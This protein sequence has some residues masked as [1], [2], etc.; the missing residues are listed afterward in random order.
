MED[1]FKQCS[2]CLH[3]WTTRDGFLADPDVHLVGYQANF[4][5]LEAGLFLFNHDFPD[6]G[7]TLAIDAARF[8]DLYHGPVFSERL[9]LT[10][11]CPRYCMQQEELRPCPA[12]CECAYVREVSDIVRNW[13]K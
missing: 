3:S 13:P 6:C 1:L 11:R 12:R 2:F 8:R 10:D 5:K 7:T 9:T 4:D